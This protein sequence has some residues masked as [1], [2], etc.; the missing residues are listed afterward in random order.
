VNCTPN[1]AGDLLIFEKRKELALSELVLKLESGASLGI[2]EH[3]RRIVNYTPILRVIYSSMKS[4]R[5]WLVELVL[6]PL[7]I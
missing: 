7:P 3:F 4:G 1:L 6:E 2:S 5:N